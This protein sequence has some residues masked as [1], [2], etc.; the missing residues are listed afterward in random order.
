MKDL[1]KYKVSEGM[2]IRQSIKKMDH[3]GIGLCVCVNDEDKVLGIVSDGD[4]R[5]AVLE[6]IHLEEPIKKIYNKDFIY[7]D[8]QYSDKEIKEIFEDDVVQHIPIIENGKLVDIITIDLFYK[9][10][11]KNKKILNNPVVIMSGGKGTRLDPFTRVL[12]KPLIPIG[13]D[14][15]IIKIM[16]QFGSF[17][18]KNFYL[19]IN[20]KKKMI[21]AYFHDH[22][23]EY[24]INYIEENKPLGTCGSLRYLVNKFSES[25]FVTNCD[26]MIESNYNKI[27]QFHNSRKN[28]LTLVGSVQHYTIPYGICEIDK[29]GDLIKISE[30]PEY[31]Y[32]TNTGMYILEPSILKLIPEDTL[33]DM[34]DLIYNMQTKKMKIGV[35]PVSE[36]SWVD[37][38]QWSEYK[39]AIQ[40]ME[41]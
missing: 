20:D 13:K 11:K 21:K 29:G 39:N 7:V 15:I 16:D 5:R 9:K 32:L 4:F 2:S 12:P 19:T 1:E 36:K 35:F 34:T 37:V 14:P 40:R 28:A 26:I 30:K 6:G 33:F 22:D 41:R 31:D 18:M 38:G 27:L 25:I 3:A 17:G 8:K 23:L 10:T 24:T